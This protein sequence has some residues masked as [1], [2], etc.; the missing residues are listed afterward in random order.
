MFDDQLGAGG[1][2]SISWIVTQYSVFEDFKVPGFT[3][4]PGSSIQTHL[5]NSEDTVS[6]CE[7]NFCSLGVGLELVL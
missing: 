2:L 4:S 1:K 7:Y 5:Q 3:V 6:N